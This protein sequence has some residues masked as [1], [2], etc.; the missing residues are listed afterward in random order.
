L[1]KER[2]GRGREGRKKE[3]K[4]RENRDLCITSKA[5]KI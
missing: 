3:E 4:R 1:T 2:E 5:P